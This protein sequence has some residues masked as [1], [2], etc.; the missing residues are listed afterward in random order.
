MKLYLFALLLPVTTSAAAQCKLTTQHDSWPTEADWSALNNSIS[1]QLIQTVPVASSCWP[2]NPFNSNV[3]CATVRSN[4]TSAAFHAQRP[5]SVDFPVFTNN[6]CI[7]PD[8]P[9]YTKA[10]GC[11]LRGLPQYIVDAT[12]AAQA[13]VALK[14][15]A[16]RNVRVIVKGTGHD[17]C[18]RDVSKYVILYYASVNDI[19]SSGANSLSI[20]THNLRRIQFHNNWSPENCNSQEHWSVATLGAGWTWG[21]IIQHADKHGKV[22]VSGGTPTVGIG[23]HT[24]AGG[25]GP[26][27]AIK[28]LAS[29]QILQVTIATTQGNVYIANDYQHQDLFWAVR[30]GGA[31]VYGVIT[32]YVIRTY[33]SP[34]T[35]LATLQVQAAQNTPNTIGAAWNATALIASSLP[36]LMDQ[37]I[38][39]TGFVATGSLVD[40]FIPDAPSPAVGPVSFVALNAF[41]TTSVAMNTTL[42]PVVDRIRREL[43]TLL[44]IKY[45]PPIEFPTFWEWFNAS[46]KPMPVAY[47]G[48]DSSRLLSK[49][50]IQIP[51]PALTQKIKDLMTPQDSTFGSVLVL[52]MAAGRGVADVPPIRRG[53]VLPAWRSSYIH[54]IASTAHIDEQLPPAQAMAG[55]GAWL[56]DNTE[57]R[58]DAIQRGAGSYVNEANQFTPEWKSRFWGVNYDRLK[59]IKLKYDPSETL[60]VAQGV[61]SDHWEYDLNSGKLC[62]S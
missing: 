47:Y 21:G 56:N 28:G 7:P 40:Q 24:G 42:L 54:A 51:V 23:G 1:G 27:S 31:G 50:S 10:Q 59:Q 57:L 60:F 25:H 14:W 22:V 58:W 32:E 55:A 48:I 9:G 37:G 34:R 8:S 2:G 52:T 12:G 39:G 62:R 29:D 35:A 38:T 5:E 41:N 6:S 36:D 19:R 13:A 43:G 20:W 33:T 15:A 61:G 3:D 46:S 45:T 17:L 16:D 4:W 18:G 26:L 30:G 11:T 53:A 44:T 49:Q